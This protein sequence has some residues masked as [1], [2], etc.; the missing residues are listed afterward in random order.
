MKWKRAAKFTWNSNVAVVFLSISWKKHS[1][2]LSGSSKVSSTASAAA[3]SRMSSKA[4]P[5]VAPGKSLL[6]LMP[7]QC[8]ILP[9]IGCRIGEMPLFIV[10]TWPENEWRQAKRGRN[11]LTQLY[12]RS[13]FV[14][15]PAPKLHL[16][17]VC[18]CDIYATLFCLILLLLFSKTSEL[19]A[20]ELWVWL[21]LLFVRIINQHILSYCKL[22]KL[23]WKRACLFF[24]VHKEKNFVWIFLQ[25]TDIFR[26]AGF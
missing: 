10:W 1:L 15:E 14:C 22:F 12:R 13:V 20:I 26:K 7:H 17:D 24:F 9:E 2:A 23:N 21:N 8:I 11:L 16:R 6:C 3:A 19:L 5:S 18:L 4:A 25:K